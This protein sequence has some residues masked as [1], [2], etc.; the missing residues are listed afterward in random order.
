MMEATRSLLDFVN[1]QS[2]TTARRL[3]TSTGLFDEDQD[4]EVRLFS[5]R[6]R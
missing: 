4:A 1:H 3:P 6:P 5:T 2:I